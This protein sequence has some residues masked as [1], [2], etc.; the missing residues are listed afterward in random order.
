MLLRADAGSALRHA[1]SGFEQTTPET[2]SFGRNADGC[3]R[4]E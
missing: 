4:Q 1:A 3:V 2:I